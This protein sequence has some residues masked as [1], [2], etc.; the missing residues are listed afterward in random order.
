[1]KS[2]N[3]HGG[4]DNASTKILVTS[5]SAMVAETT[6]F[7]IDLIKTRLQLHGESL[8]SSQPTGALRVA[9]GI[10][11]EQGPLGLYKGL[12]P[13]VIRHMFYTPIR[14]VG[15]E[16]LR[17][18]ISADDSSLSLPSKAVVGGIS[19]IMAQVRATWPWYVLLI[20]TESLFIVSFF[21]MNI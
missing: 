21:A 11:R 8:S 7:P 15:Y 13:A 6:T 10:V 14:I 2:G 18:M 3:Q 12:S 5:L 20:I 1:M 16:Y 9:F 4:H 17:S 19:G